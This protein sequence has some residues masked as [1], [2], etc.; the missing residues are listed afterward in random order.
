MKVSPKISHKKDDFLLIESFLLKE[1]KLF[2]ESLHL[3]RIKKSAL[4]F[5]FKFSEKEILEKLEKI[6]IK[7]NKNKDYKIRLTLNKNGEIKITQEEISHVHGTRH[8]AQ[9]AKWLVGDGGADLFYFLSRKLGKN[10]K[11][12]AKKNL[13][14]GCQKTLQKEIYPD[15]SLK[16]VVISSQRVNSKDPFL[17]HK[18]TVYR[19]F[20]DQEQKE[21]KQGGFFSVIFLNEKDEITEGSSSNIFIKEKGKLFT[22]P[23]QC[24]LLPGTYREYLLRQDKAQ[25]KIIGIPDLKKSSQIFLANS[26]RGLVEIAVEFSTNE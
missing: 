8:L 10:Q 3:E 11:R 2:L 21:A 7:N 23:L 19:S 13:S 12:S 22:P 25:E 24:G 26:V 5:G 16:K 6:K 9:G 18:T 17:Q 15:P 20:Y 1:G 4:F 14:T